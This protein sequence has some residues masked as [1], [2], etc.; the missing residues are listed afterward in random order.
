[1]AAP[2]KQL[3]NN[4]LIETQT[5]LGKWMENNS[6]KSQKL[7]VE[8]RKFVSAF[9]FFWKWV[10]EKHSAQM[11]ELKVAKFFKRCPNRSQGS[12]HLNSDTD[13]FKNGHKKLPIWLDG[14]IWFKSSLHQIFL[15]T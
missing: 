8:S 7:F 14:P 4:Y 3:L 12:F 6:S 2:T 1:M 5:F 15:Q 13:V 11:I 9:G 10:N